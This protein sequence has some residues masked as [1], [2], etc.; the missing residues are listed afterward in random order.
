MGSSLGIISSI[1]GCT[2]KTTNQIIANMAIMGIA[3]AFTSVSTPAFF[4]IIPRG[5]RGF[6]IGA[7]ELSSLPWFMFSSLIANSL[8]GAG[9]W[10]WIYYMALIL[11]VLGLAG[12]V[13]FYKPPPRPESEFSIWHQL[14]RLDWFGI[15]LFL[16]GI[17][18]FL[19]GIFFGAKS[20]TYAW[21]TA[22]VLV[23]MVPISF[24]N[25]TNMRFSE[26]SFWFFSDSGKF[27]PKYHTRCSLLFSSNM[28][29]VSIFSALPCL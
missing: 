13:I 7:L 28:C 24:G 18:L 11:N 10:R 5:N 3:T 19:L 17:T 6:A 8:V 1:V 29:A 25:L 2:A 4:E 22:K 20:T 21:N 9:Q 27:S 23:T 15:F 16:S 26:L 12:I 14:I